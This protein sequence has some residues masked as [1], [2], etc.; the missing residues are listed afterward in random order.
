MLTSI[1][2]PQLYNA[3]IKSYG[4]VALF[5]LLSREKGM[6]NSGMGV[7]PSG[8]VEAILPGGP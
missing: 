8:E 5:V 3:N 6:K 4:N 2:N 7:V 1:F